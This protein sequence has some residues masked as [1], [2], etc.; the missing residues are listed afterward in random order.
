MQIDVWKDE[1]HV[2]TADNILAVV[3]FTRRLPSTKGVKFYV[4]YTETH[5]FASLIRKYS[6]W[7]DGL[8]L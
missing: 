1:N 7:F 4:H 6:E 5:S 2:Y 8:S 3:E